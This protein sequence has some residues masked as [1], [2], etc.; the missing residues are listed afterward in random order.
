MS[1][2]HEWASTRNEKLPDAIQKIDILRAPINSS[3]VRY[4]AYQE[5]HNIIVMANITWKD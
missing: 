1:L 4:N 5:E 3:F 2:R